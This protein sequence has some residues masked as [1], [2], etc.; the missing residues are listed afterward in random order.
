MKVRTQR[1][2]SLQ[3]DS[4][5]PQLLQRLC[6]LE[7][8]NRSKQKLSEANDSGYVVNMLSSMVHE[9]KQTDEQTHNWA[10]KCGWKWA[11]K[12]HVHSYTSLPDDT[13]ELKWNKCP[14]CFNLLRKVSD[15]NSGDDASSSST[16][17]NSDSPS[18]AA[19]SRQRVGIVS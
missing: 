10:T 16:T 15:D 1:G 11:G 6:A 8:I 5:D 9:Q 3:P 19:E 14:K 2:C 7:E 18:T 17:S 12:K 4:Q 13:H